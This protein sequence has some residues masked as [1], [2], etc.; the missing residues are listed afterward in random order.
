MFC[1]LRN[2]VYLR[3]LPFKLRRATENDESKYG[4][5]DCQSVATKAAYLHWR[6]RELE[7]TLNSWVTFESVYQGGIHQHAYRIRILLGAKLTQCVSNSLE[8]EED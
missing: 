2:Y 6:Q 5:M 3:V 4:H 1:R 7:S 8:F